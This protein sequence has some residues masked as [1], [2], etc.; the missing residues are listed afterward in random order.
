M[1]LNTLKRFTAVFLLMSLISNPLYAVDAGDFKLTR[2]LLGGSNGSEYVSGRG[3]LGIMIRVNLWGA[4][5]KPGV[6]FVPEKTDL[7]TLFSYAGGPLDS[8][9]LDEITITRKETGHVKVIKVD[10]EDLLNYPDQ[11]IP[12]VQAGDVI[13]V[14]KN[15]LSFWEKN[16]G[17]ILST[18]SLISLTL[19]ILISSNALLQS[20]K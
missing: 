10:L 4:V 13:N 5:S 2:D 1:I 7:V 6:H 19:S 11:N 17:I 8:A 3:D 15:T 12:V 16:L 9:I 20:K 18:G 14:K